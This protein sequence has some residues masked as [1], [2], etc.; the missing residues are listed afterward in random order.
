MRTDVKDISDKAIRG[1]LYGRKF[2]C[3]AATHDMH[4]TLLEFAIGVHSA[5]NACIIR[6]ARSS[7]YLR[8]C[9]ACEQVNGGGREHRSGAAF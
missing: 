6:E 5:H 4:K 9:I 8:Y 7:G 3:E 2:L 1:M